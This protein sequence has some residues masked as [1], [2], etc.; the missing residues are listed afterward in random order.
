MLSTVYNELKGCENVPS[1]RELFNL[2]RLDDMRREFVIH[3]L[4]PCS[5]DSSV[6]YLR[7]YVL[8]NGRKSLQAR[9]YFIQGRQKEQIT[10]PLSAQYI[11]NRLDAAVVD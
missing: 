8:A 5:T 4:F 10:G 1:R 11:S 3:S 9:Y 2:E 6:A 7:V